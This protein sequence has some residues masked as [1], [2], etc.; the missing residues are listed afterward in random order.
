MRAAGGAARVV[1]LLRALLAVLTLAVVV[2][3]VPAALAALVG[4]PLPHAVPDWHVAYRAFQQH[5]IPSATIVK[6][7]AVI[8]WVAWI[9]IAWAVLWEIAVNVPRYGRSERPRQAPAVPGAI[10]HLAARLVAAALVVGVVAGPQAAM[11]R[12]AT[13]PLRPLTP[14]SAVVV[15]SAVNATVMT[16]DVG[17]VG[18]SGWGRDAS[19]RRATA[20]ALAS[21]V[22]KVVKGD[23]LWSVAERSLGDGTRYPEIMSLNPFLRTA[24]D[25]RPGHLLELP[26][27]ADVPADRA[28]EGAVDA[29]GATGAASGT[30]AH[31][32]E[33]SLGP[34]T[35]VVAAGE[36]MWRIGEQR[37]TEA[38]R[39]ASPTE[40][41]EYVDEIADVNRDR[42][43]H[44]GDP[45]LI[46]PGQSLDLP[47]VGDVRAVLDVDTVEPVI[48]AVEPVIDAADAVDAA[49]APIVDVAA[50]VA[51]STPD[52]LTTVEARPP[53]EVGAPLDATFSPPLAPPAAVGEQPSATPVDVFAWL[54]EQAPRLT[55]DL[56]TDRRDADDGVLPID[57]LAG[58]G[59][60]GV[61]GGALTW[62]VRRRRS[63]RLLQR[64]PGERFAD[65]DDTIEAAERTLH[66]IGREEVVSWVWAAQRALRPA[67]AALA[68]DPMVNAVRVGADGLEVL[69]DRPVTSPPDGPFERIRHRSWHL[70]A[71][72]D[73]DE[74]ERVAGNVGPLCPFL[75]PFGDVDDGVLLV[76]LEAVGAL[77]VEGD[78][79]QRS[80]FLNAIVSFLG[81]APW[82]R[83]VDVRRLGG[84]HELDAFDNVAAVDGDALPGLVDQIKAL[85]STDDRDDGNAYTRRLTAAADDW[86]GTIVVA[87]DDEP[88]TAIVAHAEPGGA[89]VV[90]G[91]GSAER[92]PAPATLVLATD[93]T[94]HLDPYGLD[95]AAVA[96]LP[97]QDA[98]EITGL[99][100]IVTTVS[101]DAV[102]N[103]ADDTGHEPIDAGAASAAVAAVMAVADVDVRVLDGL[104][105][106]HVGPSSPLSPAAN[107]L[108]TYLALNGQ[109][110]LEEVRTAVYGRHGI[111]EDSF[112]SVV[113]RVRQSLGLDSTGAAQLRVTNDGEIGLGPEVGCDANR[114]S[115]LL[116]VARQVSDAVAERDVLASA[117]SLISERPFD[118]AGRYYRW[119]SEPPARR[120]EQLAIAI[121]DAAYRA[122]TIALEH[123]DATEAERLAAVGLR[124]G[125]GNEAL[126]R[127]LARARIAAGNSVGALAALDAVGA[128]LRQRHPI[129]EPTGPTQALCD[130][131]SLL[132]QTA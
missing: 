49:D 1:R 110:A 90:V 123:D 39:G 10:S 47:A 26:P 73:L 15:D 58:V 53:I 52:V 40:V 131:L 22:W 119:A 75:V 64:E 67:V 84:P 104:P 62:V 118:G 87:F 14:A 89:L 121:A 66:A 93:G 33:I 77:R 27:G 85:R 91:G 4:W 128:A 103:D 17:A 92:N 65:G 50:P 35:H 105:V 80:S 120:A 102:S 114:F 95:L 42:L 79:E 36:S 12:S 76:N 54:A 72:V 78:G 30:D 59:T 82:G 88:L 132:H 21:P 18:P 130:E 28:A 111:T 68:N 81:S 100:D 16:G 124:Y 113:G 61:L 56:N 9:Q 11:A 74:L 31:V 60:A 46:M 13:S 69:F 115:E 5:D 2:I 20:A 107:A 86:V 29:V 83:D 125:A 43:V 129:A 96:G 25:V 37:L 44:P 106:V 57:L 24:R 51:T 7:V 63:L 38:R 127:V 55:R 98:S 99:F 45:S 71:G 97:M 126:A 48:D 23:S 94:A 6:A 101:N 108:V 70:R 32:V 117:L 112:R 116:A 8:V 19:G 34:T 109:V 3:G 41:A 122:A